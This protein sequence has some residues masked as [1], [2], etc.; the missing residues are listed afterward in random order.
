[1]FK[2]KVAISKL[3]SGVGSVINRLISIY[4]VGF[5]PSSKIMVMAKEYSFYCHNVHVWRG[6]SRSIKMWT[7]GFLEIMFFSVS[8]MFIKTSLYRSTSFSNVNKLWTLVACDFVHYTTCFAGYRWI[9]FV[10]TNRI[11]RNVKLLVR[12]RNVIGGLFIYTFAI[13]RDRFLQCR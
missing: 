13:A 1:M 5:T 3:T 7:T 4:P 12:A 11:F 9:Y 8:V 6:V 10:C 2:K